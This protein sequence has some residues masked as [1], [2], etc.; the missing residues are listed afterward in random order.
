VNGFVLGRLGDYN[1]RDVEFGI[2]G[3]LWGDKVMVRVSGQLLRRDGYTRNLFNGRDTDDEHKTSLRASLVLH[4]VDWLE[5]Y[6]IYQYSEVDEAGSGVQ[7]GGYDPTNANIASLA[8]QIAALIAAQKARGPRVI[9]VDFPLSNGLVSTGVINTTTLDA[10]EHITLKNIFSVRDFRSRVDFELDGSSLPLLQDHIPSG[11]LHQR[12][13]EI[14]AQGHWGIIQG[15]I[16]Y[17]DERTTRPA[18][19]GFDVIEYIDPI[20]PIHAIN[21]SAASA[22]ASHAF[23]GEFTLKPMDSLALTAGIRRSARSRE[24]RPSTA[25]R[26]RRRPGT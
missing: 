13:E 8:P 16:G 7:I 3:G 15:T 20:G 21:Y 25:A 12:T 19:V 2:G 17:Y 18:Q 5:N 6:T 26:S 23:Y 14:Q 24:R 9:D 4:P 1:R 22:D 11:R 10:G